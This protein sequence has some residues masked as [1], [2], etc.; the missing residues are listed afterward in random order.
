MVFNLQYIHNQL[1]NMMIFTDCAM[2]HCG[3]NQYVLGVIDHIRKKLQLL[4][5]SIY[6]Y[7]A[8]QQKHILD[9]NKVFK[10]MYL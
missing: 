10:I 4:S 2:P 8:Q 3:V 6:T 9:L 7:I 1:M 5:C